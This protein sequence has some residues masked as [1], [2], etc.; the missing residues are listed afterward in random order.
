N[1]LEH[2]TSGFFNL[3]PSSIK[4]IDPQT[5]NGVTELIV[6]GEGR[7]IVN[8]QEGVIRFIPESG[9]IGDPTTIEYSIEDTQGTQ[10][11]ATL[12]VDY[13][14]VA[15]DDT[16][17]YRLSS[18]IVLHILDNDTHTSQLFDLMSIVLTDTHGTPIGT[19]N[20]GKELIVHDEGV[21][22][23]HD[24]G[25]LHFE[26]TDELVGNPTP[27]Y[28]RLQDVKG[29]FTNVAKVT[30]TYIDSSPTPTATP[31]PTPTT[32]PTKPECTLQV[33]N[34]SDI[35]IN[36]YKGTIIK[37]L[38]NDSCIKTCGTLSFTQ[39]IHGQV[40]SDNAGTDNNIQ[41]DILIYTPE[42][43][44]YNTTDNFQYTVTDCMGNSSTATVTLDI[45]CASTQTSD[46]T[47][48]GEVSLLHISI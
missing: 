38:E 12:S 32:L 26:P 44:L 1:I 35:Q 39:G 21:W 18:S 25:T 22:T 37:V 40:H 45:N 34:D 20:L 24:D 28:Y 23:V 13:P 17:E 48:L 5:G 4:I 10:V 3:N 36:T 42:A 41:D 15:F 31:M 47:S 43:N 29:D 19:N 14:P 6:Q 9:Y 27:I 16:I 46:G 30:L 2:T 33:N 7:W 11:I 8:T